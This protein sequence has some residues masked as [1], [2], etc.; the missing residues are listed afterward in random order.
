MGLK[1]LL[2]NMEA[3]AQGTTKSPGRLLLTHWPVG[4]VAGSSDSLFAATS[5]SIGGSPGLQPFADAGLGADMTVHQGNL[6]AQRRGRQPRGRD[7]RAHDR[8]RLPGN[9]RRARRRAT[10]ATRAGRRSSRSCSRVAATPLKAPGSALNYV[11]RSAATRGR[12]SARSRPSACPTRRRSSP[13]PR[14]V[15]VGNGHG[16][17]PA[18]ADAEPADASTPTCS[19]TSS[20]G[21]TTTRA[22]GPP[23][24]APRP[25]RC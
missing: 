1:I 16:E 22:T 10:T 24:R 13:S 7:A 25:T 5:G 23:R 14:P 19:R 3:A 11:E 12:T 21:A 9:A 18:H 17:H 6:V 8:R 4:I 2:R 15:C 20:A